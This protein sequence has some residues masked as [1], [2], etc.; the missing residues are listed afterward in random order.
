[1]ATIEQRKTNSKDNGRGAWCGHVTPYKRISNPFKGDE[2]YARVLITRRL[3]R[4]SNEK[5]GRE[6]HKCPIRGV[7][8]VGDME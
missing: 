7:F 1:M 2:E 5:G 4:Q 6:L 3:W 8:P